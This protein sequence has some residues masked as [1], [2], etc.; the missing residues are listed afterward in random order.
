MTIQQRIRRA[1]SGALPSG[2][3]RIVG[4]ATAS[5]RSLSFR[6]SVLL[7]GLITAA[8]GLLMAAAPAVSAVTATAGLGGGGWIQLAHLSPNTPPVDVYLYSF[9]DPKAMVVLH[10]V[11]YGTVSP[12][13]K[14]ASGEYTVA[15]RGAGAKPGSPPV[16]ST[17]VTIASGAAY[18][19]AGLGPASGL[20]LQVLRDRLT[21]PRGESLVRVIQASLRDHKVTVTAGPQVLARGLAFGSVTGYGTADPGTWIVHVSGASGMATQSVT[22]TAGTIHTLVVLD[23][24]S[25]LMID[26]LVNA[27]GSA[28][29][30][31][32]GAA[33]GLGGTAPIPAPSLVP[34]AAVIVAGALCAAAAAYW[35]RKARH[36][37]RHAR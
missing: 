3:S 6:R 23:G 25:G 28:V 17:N 20:R 34:W 2:G 8:T 11:A 26:N 32:G 13:E 30:P 24:A 15:M 37:A 22:L 14:V 18:T 10:H 35:L 36:Q 31:K 27:A 12:Y 7:A 1:R 9:G 16:L 5:L 19:V 29:M 33:T 21:T 4:S